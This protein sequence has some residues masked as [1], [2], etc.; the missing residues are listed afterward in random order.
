M[1]SDSN[2]ARVRRSA[3]SAVALLWLSV[4]AAGLSLGGT[5]A[6]ASL[7]RPAPEQPSGTGKTVPLPGNVHPKARP[8]FDLGRMAPDIPLSGISLLLRTS[9]AQGAL[10]RHAVAAVQDPASPDYHQWLTP[11][12]YASQFGASP[13]DIARLTTWLVSQG[14]S[15][16]GTSRTA[17]RVE[18]HGTVAQIDRAFQTELHH[19]RVDGATHFAMSR[20]PSVPTSLAGIVLGLHGLDDFREKIASRKIAPQYAFPYTGPDGGQ[21]EFPILAPADF[22]KIYDVDSL[23]AMN[24]TGAGS[25]IA[26]IGRSDFNDA[27]IEA[28]RTTFNLPNNP[29][30]RVLVPGT[31]PATVTGP[32]NLGEAE[33][34]LEWAGAVAPDAA[35]EYVFIGGAPNGHTFDA[36]LYAIEQRTASVVSISYSTCED[37]L[38]PTDAA[39]EETYGDLATLEGMTVVASAGDTGAAGCDDQSETAARYGLAVQFPASIPAVVAAGGSQF[40]LTPGNQSTYLNAQLDAL[41]YIPESAWNETLEDIDAGYGGLGAGGGGV[42]RLFVKPYWQVPYTPSDGARDVP[43]IALSA[44]ADVLPYAVS[45]SWTTADGDA[46]APQPQ[47]LTA[48]GGTSASAPALAG[49]LALVNQAVSEAHPGAPVGLGNANPMLYALAASTAWKQ[50]FHDITTGDNVIPCTPGSPACPA[51]PPFQFGY[52]AGAG[53]DQV[54]GLGSIDAANLVAAWTS[55]TPTST[56]LHVEETGTAEGSPIQLTATVSSQGTTNPMTGSV[57]FYFVTQGDGGLGISGTLGT[58]PVT[59]SS[60]G[61]EVGTASLTAKAPGGLRGSGSRIGAFY[62]GDP[63]YLA[64]WSAMSSASGTS[65]LAICPTSISLTAGQMGFTFE[66]RGGSPPIVWSTLA[67]NTC[68]KEGDEIVCSSVDGGLL[69]AGPTPGSV[70]VVAIDVNDS[71]ATA[72]VTVT[73]AEGDGSTLPLVTCASD[74]SVADASSDSEAGNTYDAGPLNDARTQPPAELNGPS[75]CSCVA[76]GEGSPGAWRGGLAG[77]LVAVVA[78]GRRTRA[79]CLPCRRENRRRPQT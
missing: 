43:D 30:T 21:A 37:W 41:S 12:Q 13:A 44:S 56:M 26:V 61:T 9:A 62:S 48:F 2:H 68:A 66:A 23:Y 32:D 5:V 74:A 33:L 6:V 14:L 1:R 27:D 28:F 16:D 20:A 63:H 78:S 36:L 35:V 79:A 58:E 7:P 25:S 69:T 22:A 45:L 18:F 10:R 52:T 34:D 72:E 50:A 49:I 24:I 64:S 65:T 57:T 17:T 40:Q 54:T 67:D 8:E 42:S 29:P 47:A 11:E 53:Y 3:G 75:G 70:M 55:M 73:E 76:A 19:Y 4:V 51:S 59:S 39:F 15:V 31:G 71:Y 77:L 46:Q 60:S 38:T